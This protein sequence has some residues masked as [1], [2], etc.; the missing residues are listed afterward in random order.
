[1]VFTIQQ[2]KINEHLE[3][4]FEEGESV[5]YVDSAPFR[6]CKYLFLIDPQ[7]DPPLASINSIDEAEEALNADLE[8]EEVTPEKLGISGEEEFWGHCSNLQAWFE[9]DYDTRVLHSNLSFP[10]LRE[11]TEAGDVQAKKA[12][13]E[14]IAKRC[15]DGYLPVLVYL[16]EEE[17]LEY[18][19]LEEREII[20]NYIRSLLKKSSLFLHETAVLVTEL[21]VYY[22]KK[23]EVNKAVDYLRKLELLNQDDSFGKYWARIGKQFLS[24]A[25]PKT[26][27]KAFNRSL[28]LNESSQSSWYYRGVCWA[29]I[30]PH[31]DAYY[32]NAILDA[33]RAVALNVSNSTIWSYLGNIYKEA[34]EFDKAIR[35]YHKAIAHDKINC[36]AWYDMGRCFEGLGNSTSAQRAYNYSLKCG[37]LGPES[38]YAIARFFERNGEITIAEK[39]IAPLLQDKLIFNQ[40]KNLLDWVSPKL[41]RAIVERLTLLEPSVSY[42]VQ[43]LK[44]LIRFSYH[45][46]K[47]IGSENLY[48]VLKKIA[49][50]PRSLVTNQI[51]VS[52]E[53]DSQS[54]LAET[55][56]YLTNSQLRIELFDNQSFAVIESPLSKNTL[57]VNK[58][59]LYV[60][61]HTSQHFIYC[62]LPSRFITDEFKALENTHYKVSGGNYYRLEGDGAYVV[63]KVLDVV[64]DLLEGDLTMEEA[65]RKLSVV[66]TFAFFSSL[67][68]KCTKCSAS[69]T[70]GDLEALN[71]RFNYSLLQNR[72]LLFEFY[73]YCKKCFQELSSYEVLSKNDAL[74][75]RG[76]EKLI[77]KAIPPVFYFGEEYF[78]YIAKDSR[79][80]GLNL[81]N[82]GLETV[83]DEVFTLSSLERL[84]LREN[85]IKFL[86]DKIGSFPFL[87]GLDASYNDISKVSKKI[88]R[89]I[90]LEGLYL[91]HNK[92]SEVPLQFGNLR[93]LSNLC[94]ESNNLSDLPATFANLKSL[95][96]LNLSNNNFMRFPDSLPRNLWTL[97]LSYNRIS[98]FPSDL[99]RLTS[100]EFLNLTGNKL[101][102]LPITL[103]DLMSLEGLYL[104]QNYFS[105][106]PLALKKLK[107]LNTLDISANPLRSLPHWSFLFKEFVYD[108]INGVVKRAKAYWDACE[109][110]LLVAIVSDR[111]KVACRLYEQII[112]YLPL[113]FEQEEDLLQAK[114]NQVILY[115]RVGDYDKITTIIKRL[116]GVVPDSQVF[117][118]HLIELC[119]KIGRIKLAKEAY[120]A[121][122]ERNGAPFF[123]PLKKSYLRMWR[124]LGSEHRKSINNA[125]FLTS[126]VSKFVRL[127]EGCR[128]FRAANQYEVDL[129]PALWD[130]FCRTIVGEDVPIYEMGQ[131]MS[132]NL[133]F[134]NMKSLK[135]LKYVLTD[136]NQNEIIFGVPDTTFT[137]VRWFNL[138]KRAKYRTLKR[139]LTKENVKTLFRSRGQL[140]KQ[141]ILQNTEKQ[142]M[143]KSKRKK[144]IK[145]VVK[146]SLIASSVVTTAIFFISFILT[147]IKTGNISIPYNFFLV[148]Y[149]EVF[150]GN[151]AL[152]LT[153]V[154]FLIGIKKRRGIFFC[155]KYSSTI[156]DRYGK[157]KFWLYVAPD[158]RVPYIIDFEDKE[159][160]ENLINPNKVVIKD[161]K[162]TMNITYPLSI[163]VNRV[164]EKKG[165]FTRMDV[166]KR[167]YEAYKQIYDEEEKGKY[168]IWG[169]YI[170][171]LVIESVSYDQKEK[172]LYMFIGS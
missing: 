140:T 159:V 144:N 147:V 66:P 12:F 131:D 138:V 142:N 38:V 83:P 81:Y 57:L 70:E 61:N 55:Y 78:G 85:R 47:P 156:I 121:F 56:R 72:P 101:S 44:P 127:L 6:T 160:R 112:A 114:I 151:F 45:G 113:V 146:T 37:I 36:S 35:L 23:R 143:T 158:S 148:L 167:I 157:L 153:I 149:F 25:D 79:V 89:L 50:V 99:G 39:I 95:E 75:L 126:I 34:E 59:L 141:N 5:I 154:L 125:Y 118:W 51:T 98:E 120:K 58:A 11:L 2:F 137:F 14:E 155:G 32:M 124:K 74:A 20:I 134:D 27:L 102:E 91:C 169:H 90:N 77:G 9:L 84:G 122:R 163:E 129:I 110:R 26:A 18:L 172:M 123:A 42:T 108:Q 4:R 22:S 161:E 15:M 8:Y 73:T 130:T 21:C 28:G 64:N 165:G 10:L 67:N 31:I 109:G 33:E 76:L 145:I 7:N 93:K 60:A 29:Y 150:L 104:Q 13:K 68:N 97:H 1:M 17:Y 43:E 65:I 41:V 62:S 170:G 106:L 100:L 117:S 53:R 119:N 69:L 88:G 152:Y 52:E 40:Y 116:L 164:L 71:Q 135:A 48:K 94:L 105:E 128:G 63:D 111:Y 139:A 86:P 16:L 46:I 80:I 19:N 162:I 49:S 103:S 92:L 87:I 30:D 96:E 171:D 115:E 24:M 3:V 54:Q 136:S 133:W 168:G 82:C 107:K 132:S 166:F